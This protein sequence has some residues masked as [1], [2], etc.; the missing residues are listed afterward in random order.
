MSAVGLWSLP[1]EG[2]GAETSCETR[3]CDHGESIRRKIL[4][5]FHEGGGENA[6]VVAFI[7]ASLRIR[8]C[9]G[10][11]NGSPMRRRMH[12]VVR[13]SRK[14]IHLLKEAGG[15]QAG[16]SEEDMVPYATSD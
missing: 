14:G 6:C 4:V 7:I 2:S 3:N 5:D 10:N 15:E 13:V 9:G 8:A 12:Q 11:R 16:E 1:L